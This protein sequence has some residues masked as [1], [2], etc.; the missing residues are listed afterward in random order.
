M[1]SVR[2]E[3]PYASDAYRS[4][5]L[6]VTRPNPHYFVLDR[7]LLKRLGNRGSLVMLVF[8]VAGLAAVV[9]WAFLVSY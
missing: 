9:A 4:R 5:F 1:G 6:G 8:A 7:W 2:T 3:S